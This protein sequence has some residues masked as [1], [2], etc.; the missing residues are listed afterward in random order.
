MKIGEGTKKGKVLYLLEML[1][2]RSRVSSVHQSETSQFH[3]LSVLGLHSQSVAGNGEGFF[4]FS[5][6]D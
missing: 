3:G 4:V 1:D 5:H 6:S 2:S